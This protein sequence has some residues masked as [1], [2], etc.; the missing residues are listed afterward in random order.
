M[1][2]IAEQK[3]RKTCVFVLIHITIIIIFF[4]VF[5]G[6]KSTDRRRNKQKVIE[7]IVIYFIFYDE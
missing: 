5:G 6:V 4:C 3:K 2:R 1:I 7:K